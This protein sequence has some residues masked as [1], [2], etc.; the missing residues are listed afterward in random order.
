MQSSD[1][2]ALVGHAGAAAGIG[3]AAGAAIDQVAAAV[4]RKAAVGAGL[5]ACPR[6][7]TAALAGD[8][9]AAAGEGRRAVAALEEAAAAVARRPAVV[10]E[11]G[12][13]L[14]EIGRAHV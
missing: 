6:R 10:V 3:H 4:A 13:G 5:R 1:V 11:R 9:A 2:P 8:A 7:A 12:A 14:G